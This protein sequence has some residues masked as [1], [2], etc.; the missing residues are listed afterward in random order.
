MQIA[1]A[2]SS[3][4]HE[5]QLVE[6]Q[7]SQEGWEEVDAL[8]KRLFGYLHAMEKG[9]T[10]VHQRMM[11][12]RYQY[13][14][15]GAPFVA[16]A[17]RVAEIQDQIISAKAGERS[18]ALA[19]E[20]QDIKRKLVA[21]IDRLSEQ[22]PKIGGGSMHTLLEL[23]LGP[24]WR[25]HFTATEQEWLDFLDTVFVPLELEDCATVSW[26]EAGVSLL[27]AQ[28]QRVDYEAK[29]MQCF[30]ELALAERKVFPEL[31]GDASSGAELLLP[32]PDSSGL[33]L[34]VIHGLFLDSDIGVCSQLG[35]LREKRKAVEDL[36]D[37]KP[38]SAAFAFAWLDQISLRDWMLLSAEKIADAT[39]SAASDALALSCKGQE[40]IAKDFVAAGTEEQIHLLR[41]LLCAEDK[42][43]AEQL[44]STLKKQ[45]EDLFNYLMLYL[46]F[47]LRIEYDARLR[48]ISVERS[49]L[50]GSLRKR[51]SYKDQ[52]M[53]SKMPEAV[54]RE[55]LE[56][57]GQVDRRMD[58][59][60]KMEDYIRRLLSFPW[61]K[62]KSL[63]VSMGSGAQAIRDFRSSAR[64]T[65]N[66]AVHGQ[67]RAKK[68]IE[69][70]TG[71]WISTG[72]TNGI[73][74]G[75]GGSP[76]VGKTE[77][78]MSIGRAWDLPVVYISCG[79]LTD[80]SFLKGHGFTY[81]GSQPG[82]VVSGLTAEG[83]ENAIFV[84]DEVDKLSDS[85]KGQ[86]VLE[87]L[88]ELTDPN[89]NSRWEDSFFQDIPFNI[90]GSAVVMIYNYADRLPP[91]LMDRMMQVK[92]DDLAEDDKRIIA[93]DYLQPK[94]EK[95][96]GFERGDIRLGEDAV[97]SLI[98]DYGKE[99]GVRKLFQRLL[100]VITEVNNQR[101]EK[102]DSFELP[103]KVDAAFVRDALSIVWDKEEEMSPSVQSMWI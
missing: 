42:A 81:H 82:R 32:M 99:A 91:P 57:A 93:N 71:R 68:V 23:R 79:G 100:H 33:K 54:K 9:L 66:T 26:N 52:I 38:M 98:R 84:I 72:K 95:L 16:L 44:L 4:E 30:G 13:N 17:A 101:L 69:G 83:Y 78:A 39:V 28:D 77:M 51:G 89:R 65:I 12:N 43:P 45:E 6:A 11:L 70:V 14:A 50:E 1:S 88:L 20:Q 35:L 63:P 55:A 85:P 92:F 58:H 5:K 29:E 59:D 34:L 73:C 22:T 31:P 21:E 67:E 25:V 61:G 46:P 80:G 7:A 53:K 41:L 37:K 24:D 18:P 48:E 87:A 47:H 8:A 19:V 56:R 74:L 15:H 75:F 40:K 60:G 3:T 64:S 97:T 94:A 96:C 2:S 10:L 36:L 102:L 62:R 103:F 27:A 90:D 76:G 86:E 49:K